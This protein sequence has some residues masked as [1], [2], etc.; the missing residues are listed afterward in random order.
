[1]GL[2]NAARSLGVAWLGIDHVPKNAHD[3][4]KPFGSTYSHNLARVTWG[5]DRAQEAGED[6]VVIALTN[7]KANNGRLAKR[8]AYR[9]HFDITEGDVLAAVR[10]E[11]CDI[12]DIPALTEKLPVKE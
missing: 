5:V 3:K 9:I 4:S 10:F 1:M 11:S 6:K 7:H 2:L 12:R 8:Q